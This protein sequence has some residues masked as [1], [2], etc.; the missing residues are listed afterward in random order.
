MVLGA[1]AGY[2]PPRMEQYQRELD[3]QEPFEQDL[4]QASDRW[5]SAATNVQQQ[6]PYQTAR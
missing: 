6:M 5:R 1:R 3:Q 2:S 4:M